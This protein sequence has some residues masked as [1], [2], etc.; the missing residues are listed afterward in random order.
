MKKSV[1][2]ALFLSLGGTSVANAEFYLG[3]DLALTSFDYSDVDNATG[4]QLGAGYSFDNNV[5]IELRYLDSGKADVDGSVP[6]D[7]VFPGATVSDMGIE[8]SGYLATV[9]YTMP[10]GAQ[11]SWGLFFRGGLYDTDTEISG[12]VT[13]PGGGSERGTA[14][15]STTGL[16][17][18]LGLEWMLTPAFGLRGS[19]DG[20]IS[21]NDFADDNNVTVITV[22][23]LFR[24]GGE[25]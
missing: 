15:E 23:T 10:L 13:F 18:G 8:L 12:T 16:T 5:A 21:N 11:D 20:L 9:S 7:D 25:N 19:V 24:F 22:G 14:S 3:G 6:I 4:Y 1:L 17:V 2:L